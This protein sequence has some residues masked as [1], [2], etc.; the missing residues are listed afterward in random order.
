MHDSFPSSK[1]AEEL[2]RRMQ[3]IRRELP[4][5]MARIVTGAQQIVDW[6]Q[7]VRDFPW[8]SSLAAVAVGYWL[9]P[10]LNR[11]SRTAAVT[12]TGP[13]EGYSV[14]RPVPQRQKPKPSL[15]SGL[16][17]FAGNMLFRVSMAY[18]GQQLGEL[19]MQDIPGTQKQLFSP[20]RPSCPTPP[21]PKTS[22]S[23]PNRPAQVRR[24]TSL[25]PQWSNGSHRG[26][27]DTRGPA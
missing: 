6:R 19:L 15:A 13:S 12:S 26:S 8:A 4:Q 3:A 7:Y 14:A 24:Q 5:D 17:G 2:R 20:R 18:V 10:K 25:P 9:V 11:S 16:L 1:N 21:A 27:T 22:A 23:P